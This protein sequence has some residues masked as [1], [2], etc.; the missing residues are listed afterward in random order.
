MSPNEDAYVH[1]QL[2]ELAEGMRGMQQ[3]LRR[4][5][6]SGQ[7]SEDKSAESRAVV[8]KRMDELVSRV[9]DLETGMSGMKDDVAEMKPVTDDVK[10]WKLMGI[11][12]LGV[13]GIGG[14]V[15]GV[16]FADTIRRIGMVI[17]GRN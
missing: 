16:T 17:I 15:L 9:G 2:G 7:R 10:R 13:I 1:R 8:H 3:S 11:G 12:A 4:I 6:E 5:E 14:M